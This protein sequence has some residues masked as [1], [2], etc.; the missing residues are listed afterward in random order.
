M[1]NP[2]QQFAPNPNPNPGPVA[3][4]AN[5]YAE[6]QVRNT[7]NLPAVGPVPELQPIPLEAP[8]IHRAVSE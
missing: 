1:M 5:A 8:V 2:D 7:S 3:P 4:P 6:P